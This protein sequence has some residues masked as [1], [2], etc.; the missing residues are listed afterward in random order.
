MDACG[1]EDTGLILDADGPI[2]IDGK[3]FRHPHCTLPADHEPASWHE[4]RRP[5]GT[6]WAGWNE[7]VLILSPHRP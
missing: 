7:G 3:C 5:D 2:E 6:C 1:V 4:E